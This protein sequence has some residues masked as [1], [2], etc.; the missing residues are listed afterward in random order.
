MSF[1]KATK[2]QAKARIALIGLSGSGKTWTGLLW[3]RVLAGE[4]GKVALIDTEAGSASKYADQYAFDTNVLTTFSPRDYIKAIHE[5]EN[6]GYDALVIDSLSH[7]WMGKG[8]VLQIVDDATARSRSKNQFTEG[9]REATP[10]HNN[11]VEAMVQCKCHLIVTMRVKQDHVIEEVNGKK[12]P[13][14]VGL[15]PV[16]RDGL[17]Y[18]FDLVGDMDITHTLVIGKTRCSAMDGL[19]YHKPDAAAAMTFKQWLNTGLRNGLSEK[20][21]QLFDQYAADFGALKALA[22]FKTLCDMIAKPDSAVSKAENPEKLKIEL[23]RIATAADQRLR[24]Q[25]AA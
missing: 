18:E 11:L 14:K 16:Q 13:R 17:E 4:H 3:A 7:A 2:E 5:A 19:V 20:D 12:I 24:G 23:R 22:D 25:Q 10:E 21:N 6:A 9:W 1:V 8:G 15:A